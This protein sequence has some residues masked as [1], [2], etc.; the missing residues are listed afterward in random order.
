[1]THSTVCKHGRLARS[2][3]LCELEAL[4]AATV[5]S[6]LVEFDGTENTIKLK[7]P[8]GKPIAGLTTGQKIDVLIP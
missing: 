5:E 8:V 7:L 1:M 6:V 3:D 4:R 2:C